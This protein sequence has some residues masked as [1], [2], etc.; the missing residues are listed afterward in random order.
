MKVKMV[1]LT[2]GSQQGLVGFKTTLGQV[3]YGFGDISIEL[4]FFEMSKFLNIGTGVTHFGAIP[5]TLKVQG[6]AL[7][8]LYELSML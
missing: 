2:N 6:F 7:F 5:N 4:F 3:N 8:A 1:A